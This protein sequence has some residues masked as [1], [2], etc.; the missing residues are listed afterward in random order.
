MHPMADEQEW[1]ADGLSFT[2]TQCG[3]CCT[4]PPGYVMFDEA[5]ARQIAEHLG[6]SATQFRRKYTHTTN[7]IESIAEVKSERGYD[8]V[9]LEYNEAGK[10]LCSIY[11]VRPSQCRTW[12]FWPDNLRSPRAW[13]RT[14]RICP[15]SGEG[16]L[17]PIE[18][19]R[20]LRDRTPDV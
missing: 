16:K 12:P 14:T 7:G 4:G 1:Y 8:C 11:A 13:Q 9:F 10:A 6:I 5:E 2:C 19:I 17:V 15:G 3:D 18:K 20:I